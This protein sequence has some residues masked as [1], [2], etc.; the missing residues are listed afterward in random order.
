MISPKNNKNKY[1]CKLFCVYMLTTS[2]LEAND[3]SIWE[4]ETVS[5]CIQKFTGF[6]ILVNKD[7]LHLTSISCCEEVHNSLLQYILTIN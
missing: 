3:D 2:V 6:H 1:H 5:E 7:T 4:C